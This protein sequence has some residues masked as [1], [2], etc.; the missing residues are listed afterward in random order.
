[1]LDPVEGRQRGGE[2]AGPGGQLEDVARRSERPQRV[3]EVGL[4][5][6]PAPA[7]VVVGLEAA[8][9]AYDRR[10]GITTDDHRR[11]NVPH[12][13][14]AGDVAGHWQLAHTGFREGEVA[15]ENAMGHDSRI[16]DP[17]VEALAAQDAD[18]VLFLWRDKDRATDDQDADGEVV[19]MK[20]AKHRNGPTGE[21]QLW[22]KK[23]ETRFV[24]YAGERFAEVS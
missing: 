3:V 5:G 6:V 4:A 14:A 12:I 20:L 24:S 19:N 10:A 11:T 2:V 15:A 18:L 1:V 17:A 22:F 16:V 9:V 23:R 7:E 13:Y 21:M 8:G